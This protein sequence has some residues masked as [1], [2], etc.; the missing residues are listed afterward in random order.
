[1]NDRNTAT[2]DIPVSSFRRFHFLRFA[3]GSQST[4]FG[5]IA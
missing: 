3:S 1:M 4:S 5:M 2:P